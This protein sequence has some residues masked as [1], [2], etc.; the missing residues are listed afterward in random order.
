MP[1]VPESSTSGVRARKIA[2]PSGASLATLLLA[3][4]SFAVAPVQQVHACSC[5]TRSRQ[6]E[7][8]HSAAVFTG[9]VLDVE[10]EP[11][12]SQCDQEGLTRPSRPAPAPPNTERT[13][14]TG[15]VVGEVIH[16]QCEVP[17]ASVTV[18][19]GKH[20]TWTNLSGRFELCGLPPGQH[21]LA[22]G[23]SRTELRETVNV[24][25]GTETRADLRIAETFDIKPNW[26]RALVRVASASK[27]VRVG[28][29]VWVYSS[30]GSC[31]FHFRKGTRVALYATRDE[32]ADTLGVGLCSRSK[33]LPGRRG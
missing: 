8:R 16:D 25:A 17:L 13:D 18:R 31:G 33:V 5:A 2:T 23:R 10:P 1:P 14:K 11:R 27:G 9:K 26:E 30:T 21:E 32:K 22:V 15:C 20:A 24:E 29:K 3:A 19:V 6:W 7:V 28:S 12:S 4:V